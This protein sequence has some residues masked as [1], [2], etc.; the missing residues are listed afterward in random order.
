MITVIS[1]IDKTRISSHVMKRQQ[2]FQRH[3]F[4]L[5]YQKTVIFSVSIAGAAVSLPWLPL[6]VQV[7]T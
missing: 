1:R 2:M 6:G 4:H 5:K 3:N 7:G